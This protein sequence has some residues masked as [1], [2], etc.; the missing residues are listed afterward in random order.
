MEGDNKPY[1]QAALYYI[2]N[3]KDLNQALA[4]LEKATA[5]NPDAF[6]MFYQKAR[7]LAKLGKKQE[8]LAVSNKSVELSKAAKNDD[9][10]ALNMK[11]Q[12]EL[13]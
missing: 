9:Y 3:G 6:Y 13:K 5:Q 2:E 11:L 12:S 8:A 1:F 4:W 7:V 10:V